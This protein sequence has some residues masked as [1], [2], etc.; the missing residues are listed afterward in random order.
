MEPLAFEQF[1]ALEREHWWF[2]GRRRVYL[3]LIERHCAGA[4]IERALDLG[5]GVGGFLPGLA[6]LAR[7]VCPADSDPGSLAACGRRELPENVAAPVHSSCEALPFED[8]SF[9]LVCLFD[10]LEHLDDDLT[11]LREVHRVLRPGGR[12]FASVPAYPCLYAGNDRLANHKRRYTRRSLARALE[13]AGLGIERNTHANVL[14]FPLILPAV[15][16]IKTWELAFERAGPSRRTNLSWPLPRFAHALLYRAFAA[17]LA[18]SAR[19]DVPLGHS[20]AA[21]ASK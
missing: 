20:I 15:L 12:L 13:Q 17:E 6:Q 3:G 14:L 21:I 18:L 16:A 4:P 8:G 10:V 1:E 2:R 11:C 7:R 9:D 5:A 19:F